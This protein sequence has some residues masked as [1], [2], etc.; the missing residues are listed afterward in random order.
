M[1]MRQQKKNSFEGDSSK[2][3]LKFT[4]QQHDTVYEK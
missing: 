1:A 4:T 2:P 3:D